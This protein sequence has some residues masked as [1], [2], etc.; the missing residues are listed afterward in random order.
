MKLN[1]SITIERNKLWGT[2]EE[3]YENIYEN[4]NKN[5]EIGVINFINTNNY[6]ER[7]IFKKIVIDGLFDL[8]DVEGDDNEQKEKNKILQ[9]KTPRGI[10]P[11]PMW[12][13]EEDVNETLN[14]YLNGDILPKIYK[15]KE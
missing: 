3:L 5:I 1:D 14:D 8:K 4:I 13:T 6:K 10:E 7:E 15:M 9:L 12:I 2:I 11:E